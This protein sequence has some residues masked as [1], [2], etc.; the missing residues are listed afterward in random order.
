MFSSREIY[1]SPSVSVAAWWGRSFRE[2]P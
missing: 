2:D 1:Q